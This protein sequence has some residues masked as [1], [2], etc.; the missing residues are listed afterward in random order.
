METIKK[1]LETYKTATA[2][3]VDYYRKKKRLH[4]IKAHGTVDEIFAEVSK[5]L[6]E[7]VKKWAL[8]TILA[9]IKLYFE[10][11][12]VEN[13]LK[14][15]KKSVE[16]YRSKLNTIAR[17]VVD[18][19]AFHKAKIP[20]FFIV[21]GPGSGK[22]TQC[23]R[24]VAKYGLTH[25]SSGELLRNEVKSG[26]PRGFLLSYIM[27]AGE[28]VP[29]EIVLD[30]LKENIVKEVKKGSK[31]FLIDGYPR[32]IKQGELFE[33]EIQK[34]RLVIF[35]DAPS[36]ALIER[37]LKRARTSGR[38][39]DNIET[40]KKSLE[41]YTTKTAPVVDYYEKQ[42]KLVKINAEGTEDEVFA[43]VVK[44]IDG[45]IEKRYE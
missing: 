40:I 21:G 6:D 30:L 23:E 36:D 34:A 14:E 17:S 37:L 44:H 31:G 42:N 43:E 45:L 28:L 16:Y 10:D 18:L 33:D 41:T 22:G 13:K 26:S 7:V 19:K 39:D 29:Y 27:E 24:I 2:P 11:A 8:I 15:K 35:L 20:I 4:T 38:S 25:L 1:R 5:H 3:V 32:D 9:I 12:S